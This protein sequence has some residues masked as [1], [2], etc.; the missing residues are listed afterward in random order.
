MNFILV[1]KFSHN[2]FL[3]ESIIYALAHRLAHFST[4]VLIR[5]ICTEADVDI[6]NKQ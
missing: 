5:K 3:Q 4:P 2:L 1:S 6:D